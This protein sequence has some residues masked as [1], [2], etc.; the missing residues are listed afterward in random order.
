MRHFSHPDC[1]FL[2]LTVSNAQRSGR[3]F[4]CKCTFPSDFAHINLFASDRLWDF[5]LLAVIYK[6]AE[7]ASSAID[8][9]SLALPYPFLYSFARFATWTL[10]GFA[11]GLVATGLWVIAHECGHQAF[12]EYKFLNNAVGWVL[13][14]GFVPRYP[15]IM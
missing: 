6:C 5:C 13:H 15:H 9:N 12:S 2:E 7:A 11:A 10:Y 1:S 14:S 4:T 8:P 3:L